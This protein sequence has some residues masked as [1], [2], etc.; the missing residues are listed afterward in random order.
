MSDRTAASKPIGVGGVVQYGGVLYDQDY[1][2]AWQGIERDRTISTML[3]DPIIGAVL[4]GIEMLVRRIDWRV[5][6]A[7]D[8]DEAEAA[9]EFVRECLDDMDDYWPGDTLAK[10]LTFLGWGWSCHEV[11]YKRR[12]GV[13][14]TPRSRFDDGKIGWY[15][16]SLR[17]QITRY[18]WEFEGDDATALIQQ[19]PQN[20]QNMITIPLDKCILFRVTSRDNSPEGSTPLRLAYDAWYNKRKLQRIEGIGI[21]RDTA[22]FPVMYI[23]GQDILNN[24]AIY[25]AAQKLVSGIRTDSQMGAVISGDRDSTGNRRQELALLN[26]GGSRAIN[27][28]PTVKRYANEVVTVFMANVMRTGQD[29]VGSFALAE[30]QG[31]LFQQAIG[32]HLDTIAQTITEQA[33]WPL[34]ALNGINPEMY[35]T[36][37]HG[38]IESADLQRLGAYVLALGTAGVL[39]NTP[40]LRAFLHEVAGLPVPE[41]EEMQADEDAEA[42]M[43]PPVPV[44]PGAPEDTEQLPP[45]MVDQQQKLQAAE[46]SQIEAAVGFLNRAAGPRYRGLLDAELV[47][48]GSNGNL[49]L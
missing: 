46:L 12:D 26:S 15:R 27:I 23:E 1:D 30:V 45:E 29:S 39:E 3:N 19:D 33:V 6:P 32:A 14:G 17:P 47:T 43:P 25:Q 9:A 40:E 10:I 49:D 7:D 28:D 24:T 18:G 35:P 41:V 2:R 44:T 34:C 20:L 13:M 8:S 21:E 48:K 36:L 22:G 31:G 37:N 4:L 38:D 16:W 42:I 11:T 5:D